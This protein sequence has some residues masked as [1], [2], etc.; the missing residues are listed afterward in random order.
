MI[1]WTSNYITSSFFQWSFLLLLLHP[2]PRYISY[3]SHSH[4]FFRSSGRSFLGCLFSKCCLYVFGSGICA[5]ERND[6]TFLVLTCCLWY[7]L[8]YSFLWQCRLFKTLQTWW[9]ILTL[10]TMHTCTKAFCA[11]FFCSLALCPCCFFTFA[12]FSAALACD[13]I[14][15]CPRAILK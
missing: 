5:C 6:V 12:A 10:Q 9:V 1:S 2:N 3:I 7:S 11:A 15:C 14:F 4:I 13:W 8:Q